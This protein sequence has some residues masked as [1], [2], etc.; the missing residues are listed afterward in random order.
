M[1]RA[2]M[3][4]QQRETRRDMVASVPYKDREIFSKIQN[5]RLTADDLERMEKLGYEKGY[6]T[7]GVVAAENTMRNCYAAAALAIQECYPGIS[8][9]DVCRFLTCMDEKAA[10]ALD[11]MDTVEKVWQELGIELCFRDPMERIKRKE[12][13]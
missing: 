3:R 13:V 7:A 1:G 9:D 4:R 2:E 11:A 6:K 12:A 8:Q 5:G 10:Y